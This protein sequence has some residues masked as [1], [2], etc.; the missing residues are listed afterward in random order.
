[1][2][3]W[4]RRTTAFYRRRYIYSVPRGV[5]GGGE[6]M[7]VLLSGAAPR[8]AWVTVGRARQ[9]GSVIGTVSA[10]DTLHPALY[11]TGITVTGMVDKFLP[12]QA[13]LVEDVKYRGERQL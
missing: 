5:W 13:M 8:L 11:T 2:A 12:K 4:A 6:A 3:S 10:A 1:M 7:L 9:L